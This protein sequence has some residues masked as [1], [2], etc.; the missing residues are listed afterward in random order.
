MPSTLARGVVRLLSKYKLSRK[1]PYMPEHVLIL[2]ALMRAVLGLGVCTGI[3][4]T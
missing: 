2:I 1:W 4:F 3:S